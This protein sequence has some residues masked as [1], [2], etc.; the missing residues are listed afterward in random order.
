MLTWVQPKSS[1]YIICGPNVKIFMLIHLV[2]VEVVCSVREHFDAG[3]KVAK[4]SKLPLLVTMKVCL[5]C[6]ISPCGP[7]D[8]LMDRRSLEPCCSFQDCRGKCQTFDGRIW[9][10]DI[11]VNLIILRLFSRP[12]PHQYAYYYLDT[13]YADNGYYGRWMDFWYEYLI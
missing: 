3:G 12:K 1:Q 8:R 7:T 2:D 13:Y 6:P 11:I 5:K 4:I 9:L 10:P